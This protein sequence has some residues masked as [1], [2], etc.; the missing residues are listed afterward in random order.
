LATTTKYY[1]DEEGLRR[2]VDYIHNE[3]DTKM[4]I[5]D[6]ETIQNDF[7]TIQTD[8]T[9]IQSDV[10]NIS[11]TLETKLDASEFEDLLN[12]IRDVYHY[13]GSV[14]TVADLDLI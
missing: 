12:E 13:R 14:E 5:T 9:N 8:V 2:L 1:L 4:D 10:E 3:L 11:T 7:T 6:F